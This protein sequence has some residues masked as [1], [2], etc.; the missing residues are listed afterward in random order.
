MR[1]CVCD[2]AY[3]RRPRSGAKRQRRRTLNFN[4]ASVHSSRFADT[5]Q[6]QNVFYPHNVLSCTRYSAHKMQNTFLFSDRILLYEF[7]APASNYIDSSINY[8][9]VNA[10][11]DD[12]ITSREQQKFKYEY[13]RRS[14]IVVCFCNYI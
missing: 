6:R 5:S 14:I 7:Y 1:A 9:P 12:E 13:E 2:R 3:A 8:F 10:N 4:P 11:K